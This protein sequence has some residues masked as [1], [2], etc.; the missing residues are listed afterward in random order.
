MVNL[1]EPLLSRSDRD[2]RAAY[3]LDFYSWAL[4]Q[5]ELLRSGRLSEADLEHIA[6]EIEDLSKRER[7]SLV[8]HVRIVIEH[9]MKLQA[10]PAVQPRAGWRETVRRVREDIEDALEDSPSLRRELAAIIDRETNRA[11]RQVAD[12][13]AE[14]GEARD[15]LP[16]LVYD[17]SQI[18][19]PW[20]PD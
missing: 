20:M 11:R 3:D 13:L 9:L 14:R 15:A 16:G 19:G 5:A 4:E 1:P 10:S 18:L 12:A 6:E 8:S 7:R 2:T 17:E